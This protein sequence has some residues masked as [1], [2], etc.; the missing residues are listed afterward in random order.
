MRIEFYCYLFLASSFLFLSCSSEKKQSDLLEIPVDINQNSRIPLSEIAEEI[1]AIELELTN[2]SLINPDRIKRIVTSENYIFVGGM[3]KILV[4]NKS[5]KFVRS[6]GSKGQGPGEYRSIRNLAI[7]ETNGRLFVNAWHKIIIYD[8]QGNFLK[9]SYFINQLS[10]LIVDINY[11]NNELLIIDYSM[12]REDANGLFNHS[13]IYRLNDEFQ[14]TDSCTI[15]N[16]YE[17]WR[18]SSTW[19]EDFILPLDS[20]VYLYYPQ[21]VQS[22]SSEAIMRKSP[23]SEAIMRDTLYCLENN[24]LV[25]ELKLKFKNNGRNGEGNLFI[26]LNLVYRSS[27][28]FFAEYFSYTHDINFYCF[29]YDTKTGKGYN[30]R[31]GYTDDFNQIE[32]VRIRPFNT[33]PDLFYYWHTHM[34]PD[35]L[36]E[37][38]PTLYLGKLKK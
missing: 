32:R 15:R 25:P 33:N 13:A 36:E 9:E 22:P 28:Y 3:D 27:Q 23:S 11:I 16:I 10:G 30:M 1:T 5:G 12:G 6:I 29:L 19:A 4:F 37:P 7:D 2:E 17:P 35:D 18:V 14:I 26:S 34:K 20:T 24:R 8:F 21:S 31:D 38:N